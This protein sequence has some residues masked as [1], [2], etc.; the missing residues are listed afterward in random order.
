MRYQIEG[1][2]AGAGWLSLELPMFEKQVKVRK[3]YWQLALPPGESLLGTGGDLAPEYVWRWRDY[4]IGL[5]RVP[6][7]EEP[8]LDQW[9]ALPAASQRNT[10]AARTDTSWLADELPSQTNR[11]LFSAAGAQDKFEIL[12]APRWFLMLAASL[13]ALVLGLA[14]IYVPALHSSRVLIVA[15]VILLIAV[16]IWPEPALLL[17]QAASFGVCLAMFAFVMRRVFLWNEARDMPSSARPSSVFERSS[18]Q[19]SHRSIDDKKAATTT[20][21]IAI[22]VSA[23][24]SGESETEATHP[25]N[26]DSHRPMAEP[27]VGASGSSRKNQLT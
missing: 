8:Q 19:L 3:T 21:S 10:S 13:A 14:V 18:Q 27:A 25:E 17:A 5:E 1:Q 11:Y 24:K 12:A 4:G 26:G 20:A 9:V 16:L 22:D 2:W 15:A 7:K 23:D 6:L